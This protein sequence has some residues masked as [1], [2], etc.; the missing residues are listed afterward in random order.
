MHKNSLRIKLYKLRNEIKNI[1]FNTE[2][3]LIKQPTYKKQWKD[4]EKKG[5]VELEMLISYLYNKGGI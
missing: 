2:I 4:R 5:R 1:H 3:R